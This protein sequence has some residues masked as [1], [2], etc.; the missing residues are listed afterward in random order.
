MGLE[1]QRASTGE[2]LAKRPRQ[3]QQHQ[4]GGLL[5]AAAAPV[6]TAALTDAPAVSSEN[7]TEW[8]GWSISPNSDNYKAHWRVLPSDV[9]L[10]SI[11]R[12]YAQVARYWRPTR[13]WE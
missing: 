7:Q 3:Q 13:P 9:V 11:N 6:S 1:A 8:D 10:V 5:L 4:P 12:P 2:P